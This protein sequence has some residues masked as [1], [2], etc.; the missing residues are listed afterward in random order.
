[1]P[2]VPAVPVPALPVL[3]LPQ[4]QLCCIWQ[5]KPAPQ[6]ALAVQGK[7]YFGVHMLTTVGVHMLGP[8][9]L[10][11]GVLGG[12]AQSVTAHGSSHW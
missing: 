9:Q 10:Q 1:M 7:T 2:A 6:S 8:P 3:L 4:A 12:H 5:V 11:L